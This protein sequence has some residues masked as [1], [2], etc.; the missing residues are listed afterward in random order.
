[1]YYNIDE[2]TGIDCT[3]SVRESGRLSFSPVRVTGVY[4]NS[5]VLARY[6]PATPLS[7]LSDGDVVP[8]Q[9]GEEVLLPS[10]GTPVPWG[11]RFGGDQ[12][13]FWNH[14][15]SGMA[16]ESRG[17]QRWVW[18]YRPRPGIVAAGVTPGT[19]LFSGTLT[20]GQLSGQA[21]RFSNQCG[22][23]AY[24]VAGAAVGTQV[25]LEG[26]YQTRDDACNLGQYRRD[27]LSF[28]FIGNQP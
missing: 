28:E 6:D 3:I 18:Y 27:R 8:Q 21:R 16:W 17:D 11:P 13:S 26:Q 4:G 14:N 12:V 10:D 15:G 24:D 5:T 20:N 9:P 22:T 2:M 23:L 25:T 1:M 7:M 19:L